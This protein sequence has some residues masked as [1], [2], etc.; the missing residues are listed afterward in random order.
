MTKKKKK[1]E[2]RDIGTGKQLLVQMIGQEAS[3]QVAEL[4]CSQRHGGE[5]GSDFL[6]VV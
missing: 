4:P 1:G 6:S 2:I 3:I 5:R